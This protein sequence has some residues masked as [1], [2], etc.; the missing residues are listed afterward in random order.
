MEHNPLCGVIFRAP[1]GPPI[2][3]Y[4]PEHKEKFLAIL[5]DDWKVAKTPRQKMLA[6]RDK[7]ITCLFFE[8]GLRL[9]EMADLCLRDVNLAQ[10]RVTVLFGKQGKSRLTGFG[11]QTKRALWRYLSLRP[12]EV[13]RDKLWPIFYSEIK[14]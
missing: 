4:K 11:P 12:S 2:E 6:A 14:K 3:P 1:K 13:A 8:S 9:Q 10:Q 7:A 5:D